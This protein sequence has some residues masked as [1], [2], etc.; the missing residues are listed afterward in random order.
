MNTTQ[1]RPPT[2]ARQPQ[3]GSTVGEMQKRE[4]ISFANMKAGA[5]SAFFKRSAQNGVSWHLDTCGVEAF[6]YCAEPAQ[7]TSHEVDSYNSRS[8]VSW[9]R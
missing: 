2:V 1:G 4:T 7:R 9:I 8:H 6:G 5:F 3:K